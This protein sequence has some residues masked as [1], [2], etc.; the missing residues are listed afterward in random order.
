MVFQRAL[1]AATRGPAGPVA[2]IAVRITTHRLPAAPA[3]SPLSAAAVARKK[4]DGA[5]SSPGS[6]WLCLRTAGVATRASYLP[7]S[8]KWQG[9]LPLHQAARPGSICPPL[10][11]NDSISNSCA[12]VLAQRPNGLC[13]SGLVRTLGLAF[14][15]CVT[16]TPASAGGHAGGQGVWMQPQRLSWRQQVRGISTKR[17]RYFKM[18]KFHK[19]KYKKKLLRSNKVPFVEINR[20][21]RTWKTLKEIQRIRKQFRRG[22]PGKGARMLRLKRQR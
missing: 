18:R 22:I 2:R 8:S 16:L 9:E 12:A 20:P 6:P 19:K 11:C 7:W 10:G 5:S 13:S 21:K 17:R 3:T 15:T 14:P 1:S 4:G